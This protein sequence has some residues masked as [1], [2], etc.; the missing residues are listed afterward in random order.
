MA[1][2]YLKRKPTSP[3]NV[4]VWTW[5]S[6]FKLN[7]TE[8]VQ[9]AWSWLFNT[10]VN[11][12]IL[13]NYGG[14]PYTGVVY[15]YD[16][17]GSIAAGAA[18]SFRDLNSWYHLTVN[19]DSGEKE[20]KERIRFY[21]NGERLEF[22]D[23][24][25]PTWPVLNYKSSFNDHTKL[26]S[27]GRWEGG[28]T[29]YIKAQY[30]DQFWVDGQAIA[31]EVFGFYKNGDGYMSSGTTNGTDF[32]S[33][34]WCPRLPKSI[35]HNINSSGG[36]GPNGF[37]LPMN[38]SSNPGADFHCT[39]NTIVKLK[40]E[41]EPQP[42]NGAPTTSDAFVSQL[43][44][45]KGSEDLPFEGVV[46]FG[47][48]G[49]SSSLKFPDHSDLD[50]GGSPF[51]AECWIYPQDTSGAGYG[52]LFNKGFGFQVYWKDD[53]E[54][55]QLFV[56]GDGSNYNVI[57]GVT[58]QNG[59]VPK[60]K[61]CH[62]A[63]VREPGN[64]TWKMFT[65]GK[66]T[67]G[68]LVVSGSVHNNTNP[69][70][71]GDYA[72]AAGTYEFKGFISDFRLVVGNALYTAA[73]TPP[74]TRLT[75]ITNT[76]LLCCQS[77]TNV[78]EAAVAPTTGG[79]AGGAETFATKNEITG[80]VVLAVPFISHLIGSNKVTNGTFDTVSDGQDGYDNGNGTIDG[81]QSNGNSSLSINGT[82]LRFTQ[83]A[84]GSWQGGN[85]AY[86][87]G[88]EFVVGK[89]YSV[90][91]KIRS[92]GNGNY[93]QGVGSRIQKGSSWHSSNTESSRDS[94]SDPGTEWTTR[95]WTWTATQTNYGIEFYNWY[96]V[97]N[98][99]IEID[100]VEVYEQDTI[101]DYSADIRGGGTNKTV[102]VKN[103]FD[104]VDCP[105]HYG[106]ALVCN[107]SAD[108]YVEVAANADF[109]YL[110][111][112]DHT[113]EFWYKNDTWDGSY[114]PHHSI[115]GLKS[116]TDVA[117][118]YAFTDK[119]TAEDGIQ[120]FGTN[121]FST[122]D[123]TLNNDWNHCAVEQYT[124]SGVTKT[125]VY[126]NGVAA[127]Q[128]NGPNGYDAHKDSTGPI[129]I[130]TDPRSSSLGDTY[131]FSGEIQDV[132][133]YKGVAK[134]KGGFDVA[135]PYTPVNFTGD[136]WRTNS[137][138]P[139]NNFCTWNANKAGPSQPHQLSNGNLTFNQSNNYW[140]QLHGTHGMTTGK[141]YYE[142][143]TITDQNYMYVG[144]ADDEGNEENYTSSDNHSWALL[145][146]NGKAYH[147]QNGGGSISVDLNTSFTNSDVIGVAFDADNGRLWFSKNGTWL[148]SGAPASGSNPI[149]DAA[150]PTGVT[151]FP[152]A[153][154]YSESAH[155]NFGQN[156][157]FCGTVTAGTN[158]DSNGKG[159]FKYAPPS[160]FLA[161]CDDNLP[162]PTI[163]DP[164]KHFKTVLYTGDSAFSKS[165]N[166]VGFKPDLVWIKS[167]S[168]A[169]WGPFV[170]SV[171]GNHTTFYTN[172][173]NATNAEVHVPNFSSDGFTVSDID[174]GTAN[175]ADYTY[176]A[177]CWK[178]GG[179][180]VKNNDGSVS[181]LVSV[182]QEAG[183]SIVKFTSQTS[184]SITVGH[185]LGKKPAFWL[186]KDI[187]GSTGWYA[188]HQ[189]MGSSAWLK[190]N[191]D[192]ATTSNAAAWGGTDPT[193]TVFTQGSGFVNQGDVMVYAWAEI[194]GYSKFGTYKG[195]SSTHGGTVNCGFKPAFV[196]IKST[197]VANSSWIMIDS[198]RDPYNPCTR[199]LFPSYSGEEN[200]SDPSGATAS[201]NHIDLLSNGFKCKSNNSWTNNSGNTY[202]FAAFAESPFQTANAK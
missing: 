150:I 171:R 75:N 115:I 59:S 163:P 46:R 60:G 105:S 122:G 10:S 169:K 41:D 194:E 126:I 113:I 15:F 92:S 44:E 37:Y 197:N 96:G 102:D 12:G 135:V 167:R 74:T 131:S 118:R 173:S 9:S 172:S 155:A 57:N 151:Y 137:D 55:L 148:N 152:A 181:S 170:D 132:R 178:A 71:I 30:C 177:W 89:T 38:D 72:P 190:F 179:K 158:T 29:R 189:G 65:N 70:S 160:G 62:I 114:L 86:A 53:I 127:G 67:Y 195:N 14:S 142:A 162:A 138:N 20:E 192:V 81:W 139:R 85:A 51:T 174:S 101:R 116:G 147:D 80:S 11:G 22:N 168:H 156:P 201:T 27:I 136:S 50:L 130:G 161:L 129:I 180:A 23:D 87:M 164:G 157:S 18:P 191:N 111:D 13:I 108:S 107:P 186:W 21:M 106:S 4:R 149:F 188:Y 185:G 69:W 95:H 35:K 17:A 175:E 146:S 128:S 16:H 124:S 82:A 121:G 54:A 43:R 34:K 36:F 45:E 182:N 56:S 24:I 93:S 143:K 112:M 176:V 91:Y 154:C 119:N 110:Y 159:L 198:A 48:D 134:Y 64:N 109:A 78:T 79:T 133:I 184:G 77:S 117:W 73:F 196:M 8:D 187:N 61:W 39:P 1:N 26:H 7:E 144:V 90:K 153:G 97:Q 42:R 165:I 19:Y 3:G 141:F 83:T 200:V 52:A 98:S 94:S 25:T 100:D 49:T 32:K 6:W 183:F 40:G 166:G 68:P 99:W 125:T 84:S 66:L 123:Q 199:K 33:G 5:A 140:R 145:T 104:V 2:E 76:K 88:S 31:P 202:I 47:G 58:S 103:K 28:L 193:D 63:V 120:L